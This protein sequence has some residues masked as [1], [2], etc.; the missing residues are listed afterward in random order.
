MGV[1]L[2]ED[3]KRKMIEL[4]LSAA[5]IAQSPQTGYIHLNYEEIARSDTIPLL[6]NFSFA[7]ALFRSRLTEN[8]FKGKALLEKLLAF[9]VDGNFPVYLHEYPQC[10][11]RDFSLEILPVLHWVLFHFRERLAIPFLCAW[12]N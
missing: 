3:L 4:N 5:A 7:L 10:K 6:E 1:E 11:D 2:E 8:V 12:K 9:E